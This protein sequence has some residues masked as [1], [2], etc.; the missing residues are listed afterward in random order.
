MRKHILSVLAC[1]L[2]FSGVA[3]AQ[4]CLDAAACNYNPNG[5]SYCVQTEV[6]A[7]HAEGELAGMTTYRVYV[8]T[9]TPEDVL[10]VVFGD[11]EFPLTIS[12][13]TSF[14]QSPLGGSTATIINPLLYPSFPT[15]E[16]DSW[17][18]IGTDQ[19]PNGALGEGVVSTVE[20]AAQPWGLNF[21]Q[22]GDIVINTGIGGAWYATSDLTN[23]IAGEDQRILIGQFTTDGML[24]GTVNIAV[25]PEGEQV[26]GSAGDIGTFPIGAMCDCVYP[27][28]F[29]VDNDGDGF[30]STPVQVCEGDMLG[31]ASVSG[32]CNDNTALAFPGNP[33]E[34]VGDGIDGDCN[35][36]ETCY[37]DTD[38]DGYRSFDTTDFIGSPFNINCSEFGEAYGYQ[39]LDCNDTDPTLTL[40][41]ADGNCLTD[42]NSA[43][44]SCADPAACNFN[45]EAAVEEDNCE[46]LSCQGCPDETACNYEPQ[47]LIAAIG[48]CDYTSCA[49]CTDPLATNYNSAAVISD[50]SGCIYTGL[51]AI[52]PVATNYN[53][54]IGPVGHYTN[55]VYAL[56]PPGTIRLKRVWGIKG[57]EVSLRLTPFDLVHQSAACG[58]WM[59]HELN[60]SAEVNGA[61]FLNPDCISDSWFTIGGGL[62][63]GPEL[64]H[65]GFDPLTFESASVFDSEALVQEG[66]SLG[67]EVVGDTGGE[68]ANFCAELNNR[69]GCSNA[70]RIARVTMPLGESFEMQAG[71]TYTVIGA[72]ER[73]VAGQDFTDDSST[74]S[75]GGGGGELDS[76]DAVITDGTT[77]SIY[78]CLSPLA[79]N[80]NASANE[81]SG[82]CDYDSCAGCTYPDASNFEEVASIDDGTCLFELAP[83]EACFGDFNSD[84]S[85]GSQDL[86]IFLAVFNNTCD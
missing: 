84:G 75:D 44:E 48:V 11:D 81:D 9:D 28:T 35:G 58:D 47:A 83:P 65:F 26:Q 25:F 60:F 77:N 16:F 31:F 21:E 79:C 32:D 59:P 63:F 20:D 30:G 42:V 62:G 18:T 43:D 86:L 33:L 8:L 2:L 56:L 34:I 1:G 73:S 5:G 3:S 38:N 69:P 85:V 74:V 49:G 40:A 64:Q 36:A 68:P 14:Y 23:G 57:G 55:D 4:H 24:S 19:L 15:L 37:R 12:T 67:W 54:L 61:T 17:V 27:T 10:S 7:V 41:D 13:S 45:P 66:D 22:G 52:A 76:D 46:Y 70:V 50:D 72:G 6:Y 78:G 29:Y 71:L 82:D 80:Y 53:G 39:P 51:L